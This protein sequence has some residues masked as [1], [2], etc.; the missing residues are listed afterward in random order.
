MNELLE[1]FLPDSWKPTPETL[2]EMSRREAEHSARRE[3]VLAE[4]EASKPSEWRKA[5][6]GAAPIREAEAVLG[7]LRDTE[8][9]R[10]A[11]D[12]LEGDR[13]RGLCISGPVG[14]GKTF[15]MAYAIRAL[16]EPSI[17]MRQDE[18]NGLW[19]TPRRGADVAWL[20]PDDV[21]SATLHAYEQDA[22]QLASVVAIDDL[23]R[24]TKT[25][26]PEAL[27]RLLEGTADKKRRHSSHLLLAT[28][29]MTK[30]EMRQR[31][32]PRVIDRLNHHVD[33]FFVRGKSLRRDGG[34]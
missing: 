28:T 25:S 12:W 30:A 2:A 17:E 11:K 27:C 20:N 18:V 29:N 3:R 9:L 14:C 1:K 26:F 21:V 23:G 16:V 13:K 6:L 32:E 33:L 7:Q 8:A 22:P 10:V 15:A 34:F 24:E 4:L 5:F 19:P 31:Y